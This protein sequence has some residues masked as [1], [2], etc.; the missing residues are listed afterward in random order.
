MVGDKALLVDEVAC[1]PSEMIT[2]VV[3][4]KD[5]TEDGPETGTAVGGSAAHP[6]LDADVHHAAREQV[7]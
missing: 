5:R 2:L 3:T 7:I 6:V 4:V 1:E